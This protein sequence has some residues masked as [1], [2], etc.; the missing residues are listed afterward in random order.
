[1]KRF[2]IMLYATFLLTVISGLTTNHLANDQTISG[3]STTDKVVALT[4]D[5]GP[6]YK[7]TP[8]IL[9]ILKEKQ[10]RATFFV[11]GENVE[12]CPQIFAQEVADGHEIG[13]HTYS[14]KTLSKLSPQK[15]SEEF[16]KAEK[17]IRTTAPKPTLFRPPGGFYNSQVLALAHQK[18][19]QVVLWSVDPQDWNRPP[20]QEVIDKVLKEVKPGSIILLHDGQYPLP[21]PQALG[22]IID[23]LRERGY[24]F[25]TVSELLQ[26]R[27]MLPI[28][29]MGR[30][31]LS[32]F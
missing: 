15:L 20:T 6:H 23:R 18:G 14:H 8:Q 13:T 10:V 28:F 5:D 4:I 30:K 29:N 1:M 12:H 11:L 31:W 27:E 16:D 21:T 26:H 24:E 7:V 22:V 9:T 25:V 19:Y 3:V 17:V 2:H 32:R